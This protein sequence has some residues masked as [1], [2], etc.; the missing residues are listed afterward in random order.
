MLGFTYVSLLDSA[1][2][3]LIFGHNSRT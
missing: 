1:P 2:F 3:R